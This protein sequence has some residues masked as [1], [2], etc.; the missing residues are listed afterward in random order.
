MS[1]SFMRSMR[2]LRVDGFGRWSWRLAAGAAILGAW[3]AWAL[4]A[5][6]GVTVESV[7]ARLQAGRSPYPVQPPVAGR[8]IANRMRL[9]MAVAEGDVLVELDA[10]EERLRLVETTTQLAAIGPQLEARRRELAAEQA[11]ERADAERRPI[12][13]NEARAKLAAAETAARQAGADLERTRALYGGG[14]AGK[15]EYDKA[16]AEAQRLAQDANAERLAVGRIDSEQRGVASD[17]RVRIEA[18]AREIAVLE[19]QAQDLGATAKRLD[20]D[21]TL[22]TVRAGVSGTIA[23]WAPAPPGTVVREGERLATIVPAAEVALVADFDPGE[24]I[25][26]V[27]AGQR[28]RLRLDGFPWTQYGAVPATVERVASELRDGHVRVELAVHPEPDSRVPLEHGLPGV[29]EIELERV[30]PATLIVRALGRL[31]SH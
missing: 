21:I 9:G 14:H 16:A 10:A 15:A 19:G 27:R 6:V 5:Q 26:R 2:A 11:A 12:A 18:V 1:L 22:R 17:R 30:T 28:A 7:G 31:A 4:L 13:V 23:E 8:V 20:N 3:I 25:G 29:V 24:A